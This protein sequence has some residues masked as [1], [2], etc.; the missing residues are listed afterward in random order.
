MNFTSYEVDNDKKFQAA[1]VRAKM[2]TDD[3]TIPLTLI[4]KDFYK[5]ESAIFMLQGPGQY[6][7]FKKGKDGRSR[8]AERKL[9]KHGFIYPLLMA[10]GRLAGSVT[11]PEHKDAINQIVNKRTLIIGTKVPYGVYHQSDAPRP[12]MPLR[13]FLFIGPES[14]FAN[15]DQQGRVGR[16]L[17]ILNSFILKKLGEPT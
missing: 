12:I 11:N 8:Y 17:N 10:T 5:S 14:T 9:E 7:D 1:I 13:K 4:A 2:V 3:L 6:P 15:S 16:W